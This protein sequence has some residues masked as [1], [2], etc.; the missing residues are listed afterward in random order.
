[1]RTLGLVGGTSWVSTADYYRLINE[2]INAKLGGLNFSK[3]LIYSFNYADIIRNNNNDDWDLTFKWIL[4]ASKNLIAGGAEGIVLCANTM[5]LIAGRLQNELDVPVIHI[6]DATAAVIKKQSL[7]KVGL[8]GTQFTMEREFFKE[9]L[10][11]KGIERIIPGE[12]DRDFIQDTIYNE[13]GK[14]IIRE[15]TKK[16]YLRIID[17]LIKQG[18]EGIILGCTEIPLLIEQNDIDVPAF[19]TTLIHVDAVVEFALKQ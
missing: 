10:S 8:L 16:R 17:E 11:E 12:A 19:D 6:A 9:K 15:E 14:G 3:C 13:L 1:M 2:K 5:H 18:A 7:K 4:S